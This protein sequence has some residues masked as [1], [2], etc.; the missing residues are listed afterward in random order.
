MSATNM[1]PDER[2]LRA[3]LDAGAFQLGAI[4]GRWRLESIKWPEVFIVVQ[5]EPRT[6]APNEYGFRFDCTNYPQEAPTARPWDIESNAPLAFP[7][8]PA[9][10]SRIPAIFKPDW[11]EG[12]CL[13]L[14]CDRTSAAGHDNWRTDYASLQ[15]SQAKGIALYLNE[16]HSLLT[17]SDYTGVRNA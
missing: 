2:A 17:S 3:D 5:A 10:T 12:T 13:Y 6:G 1:T 16:L 7:R 14:P 15:W 8:W 9:G 11:K 4:A